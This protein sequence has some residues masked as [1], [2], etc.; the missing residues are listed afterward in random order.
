MSFLNDQV[1]LR[2][3]ARNG[4]GLDVGGTELCENEEMS[5]TREWLPR[6]V[7]LES[8]SLRKEGAGK[9]RHLWLL[10]VGEGRW[11]DEHDRL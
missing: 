6:R 8:V 10:S 7:D 3:A 11:G 4:A 5:V 2:R 1:D 9:K